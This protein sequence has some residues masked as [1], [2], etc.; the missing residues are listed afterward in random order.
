MQY[1]TI[2]YKK[3]WALILMVVVRGHSICVSP[4]QIARD[5]L[6]RDIHLGRINTFR[7]GRGTP[8]YRMCARENDNSRERQK[9]SYGDKPDAF[10]PRW[11]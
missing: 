7:Q 8:Y 9:H 6:Q 2:G 11:T 3:Y 4:M 5:L 1:N 10:I